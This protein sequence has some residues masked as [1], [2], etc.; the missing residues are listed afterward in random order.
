MGVYKNNHLTMSSS[1]QP[2]TSSTQESSAGPQPVWTKEIIYENPLS[3]GHV[4]GYGGNNVRRWLNDYGCKIIVNDV[5]KRLI[6]IGPDELSVLKTTTEVQERLLVSWKYIDKEHR[7]TAT[8]KDKYIDG[9][10]IILSEKTAEIDELKTQALEK[11]ALLTDT[12]LVNSFRHIPG[13]MEEHT[14]R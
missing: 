3:V 5:S 4:I 7:Q 2:T 1:Y 8:D 12:S 13:W 10:N 9:V 14:S 6:I 11:Y